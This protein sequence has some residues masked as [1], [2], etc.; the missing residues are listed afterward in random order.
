MPKN[1]SKTRNSIHR[2]KKGESGNPKGRPRKFVCTLKIN[3]YKL[4]EI[5]DTLQ[6]MIAMNHAELKAIE[7]D[8][9]CTI[10]EQIVAGALLQS[11]KK[12]SLYNIET[13]LTRVY[14]KP[15]EQKQVEPEKP[16]QPIIIISNDPIEAAR[17][18]QKLMG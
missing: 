6:T 4:S 12:K 18:Y 14:G 11:H 2:W 16:L 3:G 10:L 1:S 5:N 13:L 9:D 15:S 8:K 17:E 7:K